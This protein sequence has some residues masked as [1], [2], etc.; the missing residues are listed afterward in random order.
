LSGV[1]NKDDK[2]AQKYVSSLPAIVELHLPYLT[3]Q[4]SRTSVKF[5][6]SNDVSVNCLLGMSFINQAKLVIDASD[7]VVKSKTIN[8]EPLV[9]DYR[10]PGR[11][12]PNIQPRNNPS[13]TSLKSKISNIEAA[14]A[15]INSHPK[16]DPTITLS[17]Q[18]ET[19]VT[20]DEAQLDTITFDPNEPPSSHGT[21]PG[22]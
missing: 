15:F 20:F 17:D 4:G 6:V 12:L 14:W 22:M 5:A 2:N 18:P 11:S 8:V 1:I 16:I 10:P 19:I 3:H 7:H 13:S 9:I 21:K